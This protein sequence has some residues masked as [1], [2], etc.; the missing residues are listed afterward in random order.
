MRPLPGRAAASSRCGLLLGRRRWLP[1]VPSSGATR[2]TGGLAGPQLPLRDLRDQRL[3]AGAP[4]SWPAKRRHHHLLRS[5]HRDSEQRDSAL[6]GQLQVGSTSLLRRRRRR[7]VRR[8][9]RALRHRR[10]APPLV[11]VAT[12]RTESADARRHAEV[13]RPSRWPIGCRTVRDG[14]GQGK[15]TLRRCRGRRRPQQNEGQGRDATSKNVTTTKKTVAR[16]PAAI[17]THSP[18]R[19]CLHRHT[20]SA[21]ASS[22]K[23][24]CT[25]TTIHR[26]QRNASPIT[27]NQDGADQTMPTVAARPTASVAMVGP[28]LDVHRSRGGRAASQT[29]GPSVD[30]CVTGESI[31]REVIGCCDP[32]RLSSGHFDGPVDDRPA[33]LPAQ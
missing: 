27:P 31:E 22:H 10:H 5:R 25:T 3:P 23:P 19:P 21:A 4:R 8:D 24:I 2:R 6:A 16:T 29:R 18:L 14:I 9:E 28:V 12:L 13:P 7:F 26:A 1:G 30:G 11:L 20:H 17:A 33:G 32:R 15:G